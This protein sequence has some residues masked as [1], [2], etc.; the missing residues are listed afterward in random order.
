MGARTHKAHFGEIVTGR[1]DF[2]TLKPMVVTAIIM[3]MSRQI[4]PAVVMGVPPNRE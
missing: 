1:V 3:E 4:A 2:V